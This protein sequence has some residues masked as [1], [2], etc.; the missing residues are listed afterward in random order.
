[1]YPYHSSTATTTQDREKYSCTLLELRCP[2]QQNTCECRENIEHVESHLKQ[3]LG[4][5]PPPLNQLPSIPNYLAHISDNT[6]KTQQTHQI[7]QNQR[8]QQTL[9]QFAPTK[10]FRETQLPVDVRNLYTSHRI[11]RACKN[12]P[13]FARMV[14]KPR[15]LNPNNP[16]KPTRNSCLSN[17]F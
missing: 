8:S 15:T 17:S 9:Q 3:S 16:K 5:G 10:L 1:M 11:P 12:Q 6:M 4:L 2:E 14:P 7:H 13:N